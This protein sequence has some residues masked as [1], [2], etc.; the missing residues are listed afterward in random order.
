VESPGE[1]SRLLEF[2]HSHDLP[3]LVLGGGFNLLVRD[4]GVRG[5]VVRLA[6]LRSLALQG[7]GRIRAG[8]GVSHS[9]LTRFALEHEVG[10]LEFGV[11][12]PGTVG[13]WIAMNAGIRGREM[14]DVVDSVE[15]CDSRGALR[16]L[17]AGEV[18]FRYR[19]T[20]LPTGAVV[21]AAT[22]RGDPTPAAEIRERQRRHLAQRRA[23]QPIDQPSCGS[24]FVNP[25]GDFAGRLIEAAGLKGAREGGAQISELHANF[26]VNTGG[27]RAADVLALIERARSEVQRTAG[28]TLE[29]EVK[30]AG[31]SA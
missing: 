14:R 21:L 17:T 1:L 27:A 25:P 30:L 18:G 5:V 23:T 22:F 16:V 15:L 19:G 8:A 28:V 26:I 10:G 12:I 31:E 13:G 2:C 6:G 20:S 11:G 24:V 29:T 9:Q 7:P 3:I 4:A